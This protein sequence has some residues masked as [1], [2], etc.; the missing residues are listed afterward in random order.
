MWLYLV[1]L[2][3]A[4]CDPPKRRVP[5]P[6]RG[7]AFAYGQVITR[8]GDRAPM[9]RNNVTWPFLCPDAATGGDEPC[10]PQ[11][12]T[13][14]GEHQLYALGMRFRAY[15]KATDSFEAVFE[16]AAA[17]SSEFQR[18]LRS[19]RSF[20]RGLYLSWGAGG[21]VARQDHIAPGVFPCPRYERMQEELQEKCPPKDAYRADPF[22]GTFLRQRIEAFNQ[23]LPRSYRIKKFVVIND[24]PGVSDD[25]QT[26][27]PMDARAAIIQQYAAG[28]NKLFHPPIEQELDD[29]KKRRKEE[30]KIQKQ[31]HA[32]E[33]KRQREAK[34][35]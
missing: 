28:I 4:R 21:P 11:Q 2:A 15:F 26:V 12:L 9:R 29:E 6:P 7:L 1:A 35:K 33:K 19:A 27:T 18:T 8:H 32:E 10:E 23:T 25:P 20:F 14:H 13:S 5:P 17:N 31:R 30:E 3:A 24:L 16:A 34:K 22:F